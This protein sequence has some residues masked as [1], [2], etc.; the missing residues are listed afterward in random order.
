MI[1]KWHEREVYGEILLK[2]IRKQYQNFRKQPDMIKKSKISQSIGYLIQVQNS[3]IN[4]EKQI[5]ERIVRLE[6]LAGIAQ[7]GVITR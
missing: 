2:T 7:K 3:L 1:R 4:S 6:Q 5:E